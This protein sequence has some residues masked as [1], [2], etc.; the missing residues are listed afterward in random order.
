MILYCNYYILLIFKNQLDEAVTNGQWYDQFFEDGADR[1]EA[2]NTIIN[3]V[4]N[5][6]KG[7]ALKRIK[8]T[9]WSDIADTKRIL[10]EEMP[11]EE[12]YFDQ[13][14]IIS[15][16]GA[17][18]YLEELKKD[19]EKFVGYPV[20]NQKMGNIMKQHG[21]KS[22]KSNS[23]TYYNGYTLRNNQDFTKDLTKF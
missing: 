9:K 16:E 2:I 17:R 22:I 3:I 23:R 14:Y 19:F 5:Y 12:Q 20:T 11:K 4:I 13:Q 18:I 8:P 15:K 7:Q 21:I 1:Q 10:K 6:K